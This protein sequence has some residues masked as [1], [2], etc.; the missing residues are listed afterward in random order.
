MQAT[1][2]SDRWQFWIDRGGT[3]TDLVG[4][5]PDGTLRTLKLLSENPEHYRDAAVEGIRRLLGLKPGE[6]ITA[7]LVDC[8]KMGTT[9]ATNALLERRGDR[10]LLVTTRG[11]RDALR[12]AT[13][14]R[15]RLFER[16]IQLPELLYERV[17]E[18]DE[19]VDAQGVEIAPLDEAALRADLQAAFDTGLRACAIV[20]LHGWRAPDHE[21]AA[22]RLAQAVGF[23]QIS[24]SHEVSPLMKLIPRG[25]TTV[26]DAYLSP[27]LRRYVDQVAAEMPGVRLFFMQSS[28]GL[29]E[30]RRFQGKDAILSGP[31]GGIVG[32]V[33]TAEAAGHD[34][35][36]GFDMGGTST[37]VSHFAGEF[38]RA[39]DTEVAG[40]RMR[41]PMMSIHTV[42]AGGGSVIAFDGARLRVGPASAGA[43]P[44]PASY[45][46]GGPLATTDANVML[47]R[48]Q[49][50]HFPKVFGPGADEALDG[51]V[52]RARFAELAGQMAATGKPMTAEDAAAGALQIAV[53][54]M[55]N[56][57]K[58][59][60]VARGYDVT[61]YTLQCFGGAGGQAACLVADALGMT[62]ILAH[63]FAGVLSAYG[64]GL[65]DQTAMREASIE[66]PLDADGLAAARG[67]AR[68]LATQASGELA[69]Q[70]VPDGALR[71]IARAQV[72]YQGTDTALT[73]P[74]P[75]DGPT[76]AAITA[77][78]EAFEQGYRRRFAFL[79]PDRALV[80]EAVSVE[81]LAA[82]ASLEAP[83]EA[84]IASTHRPEPLERVRMYCLAD[85]QPAGWRDAELHHR[86]SLRPG[87]RIDGPA[88]V[89]ERNATTVVDAGWRAELQPSGDLLL[90]RIRE[91]A[92]TRALGT[93]ADPVVLEVFNNLFMNIAEQMGLRLQNTAHSVNIKERLDFSCAL[94]DGQGQL[95]ANA[96]HMPVH[97][98]SMSE[99]IRSVIERNPGMKR[100]DVYVLN[101]PYHGGTH[102]PDITVVTPVFLDE[103]DARPGFFVASRGHHADIGGIT[104]GSMPPFSRDITEEGVLIDNF[105][106]VEQGRLRE[107]ELQA[108]LRA[109]P[110]PSRN[111]AQNLAD[112]RAQVAA[113]EKG[114]QELQAMVTQFGRATVE[115]Y[116]QHVQDNAEA[117]VRRVISVLKDG[118][119]TL[120]LDNGARIQVRVTVDAAARRATVDFT[121][122]SAQQPN[123]F[124]A[125]KS[126][127]MAAVLYVFRT[128]VD[129]AIPL[130]A[131]CLKPIDVI[132]PEG[133]MLNPRHPAAVVAGNVETSQCVTNALYGALGV[134]AAGQCTMNNFT[135]GDA[136][137]QYYETISGGSGAGPGFDGTSVVQTHMTNSRL[138][139]PEVL[140][141]RFPVRLDSYAIRQDS[142]GAG[143][144][145]GGQGGERR[146]R[147]L[148]P[149]TASILSNGRTAGAFGM[150]GGAPGAVGENR[151]ER[152]DGRVEVLGHIGQVEMAPG[153]VFVI[154]TPGGGGYGT[155]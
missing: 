18:A 114:V 3:F 22:K 105:Q 112:L 124:N 56:A 82:G 138:T 48:I 19:R 154:R 12:I 102:L 128:L 144:W 51:E 104:P 74:L 8:V 137:H 131:G 118:A 10:T 143:R 44:G 149:M 15:P 1:P 150:A 16:H 153:D 4:R 110:H 93:E 61:G 17:I 50:A 87:A 113:N 28:G 38:E 85:D 53:G 141:F 146:I 70:G 99:S 39:F 151:V 148:T 80:I 35:V 133:C 57:I 43:N 29:T 46:R 37:D 5:A 58:R 62:R 64:M 79:M 52:V 30:A 81:A 117:S 49:P 96:P 134:M 73:C 60:S 115:A 108:L 7:A 9:V 36:I 76:P 88:I 47:G 120:P 136:T 130:N 145:H 135:F 142:A 45:R 65:A 97:L 55:A 77:I 119:F 72:R 101:D 129:D 155:P 71:T 20:F 106:L 41:A 11:F 31:A 122:T 2:T 13:Q 140:E 127:T 6:A 32:M 147:F 139:D 68:S 86:E 26:V 69:S 66:R 27:I 24:V 98:G 91:R 95:I 111:P 34:K 132:V 25:D 123:N 42:A 109:G 75:L 54:A 63:P 100:G 152:A 92:R 94:F 14:A 89:A 103:D 121:G 125:P 83:A 107:A 23:T 21:L 67:T 84:A 126:I 33:R 90:T 40:V 78:R 59:I 116:M